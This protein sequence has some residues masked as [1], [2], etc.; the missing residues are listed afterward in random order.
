M[1][2][3]L[4][5][6]IMEMVMKTFLTLG[7]LLIVGLAGQGARAAGLEDLTKVDHAE[8]VAPG[9]WRVTI[10]DMSGEFRYTDYAAEPPKMKALNAK[11]NLAYPFANAPLSFYKSPDNRIMVRVPADKSE[12]IFGFGLQLDGIKKTKTVLDLRVDHWGKIPGRTHAPVPFYISSKGYGVFFN[13]GRFLKAYVQ[14]GNRKDSPSLPRAVD[15]SPV[16]RDPEAPRWTAMPD[17]DAV[18][19]QIVGNGMEVLVFAG[20]NLQDIVS[21]YNLYC[22][23]GALPPLWGLGFWHRVP[24]HVRILPTQQCLHLHP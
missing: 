14:S 23:G 8:K 1:E 3:L 17:S 19:V 11:S 18:E 20:E 9:I 21:R 4:F 24:S 2:I 15:R 6:E 13:T 5:R 16:T 7:T 10:G 22:G 12:S